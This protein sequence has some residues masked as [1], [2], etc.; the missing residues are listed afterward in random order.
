MQRASGRNVC[1]AGASRSPLRSSG[2]ERGWSLDK[3]TGLKRPNQLGAQEYKV[4]REVCWG[5]SAARLERGGGYTK[6]EAGRTSHEFPQG[7][8][9]FLQNAETMEIKHG[10]E[11]RGD[12]KA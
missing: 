10:G 11:E 3:E 12:G 1:G 8:G 9:I 6:Q 2:V 4:K 7:R 5:V